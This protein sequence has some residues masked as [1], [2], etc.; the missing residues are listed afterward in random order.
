MCSNWNP[1]L[2]ED[3]LLQGKYLKRTRPDADGGKGTALFDI[4]LGVNSRTANSIIGDRNSVIRNTT[5]SRTNPISKRGIQPMRGKT[6]MDPTGEG[7]DPDDED[8]ARD[9]ET[10]QQRA[11]NAD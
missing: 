11:L 8:I 4:K 2:A 1:D 7:E 3:H 5:Y 10:P 9:Y 6:Q